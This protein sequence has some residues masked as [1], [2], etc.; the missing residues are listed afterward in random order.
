MRTQNP[1]PVLGVTLLL[2]L[3]AGCATPDLPLVSLN[4]PGWRVTEAPVVWK[5]DRDATE[6]VGELL[7]ATHEDGSLFVQ[8]SKGG[9]PI[10][11]AQKMPGWWR[12]RSSLREG[13]AGGRGNPPRAV[14]WLR[15]ETLP[16]ARVSAPWR[17]EQAGDGRWTVTHPG[18]GEALEGVGEP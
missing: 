18:T 10:V 12:I 9:L 15:L 3:G 6:F 8:F 13:G 16:P 14:L 17:L 11:V 1:F 7:H 2:V 5:P 4:D